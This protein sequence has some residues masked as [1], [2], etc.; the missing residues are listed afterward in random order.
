MEHTALGSLKFY[1]VHTKFCENRSCGLEVEVD[2]DVHTTAPCSH[3]PSPSQKK[4]QRGSNK[5]N[6]KSC[7]WNTSVILGTSGIRS[8]RRY[9]KQKSIKTNNQYRSN[10]EP[11]SMKRGNELPL[12]WLTS[13]TWQFPIRCVATNWLSLSSKPSYKI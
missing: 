11:S 4:V 8:G 12:Y 13:E 6:L 7:S 9:E 1:N 10:D 5:R 3:K 2:T